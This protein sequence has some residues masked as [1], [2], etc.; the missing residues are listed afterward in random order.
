MASFSRLAYSNGGQVQQHAEVARQPKAARVQ[1]AVA[2][3]Q[4]E[5]GQRPALRLE[6]CEG[7]ERRRGLT[8]LLTWGVGSYALRTVLGD[9]A[10]S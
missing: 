7:E 2:V 3:H 9:V 8:G 5:L 6:L 1:G 10:L 4:D